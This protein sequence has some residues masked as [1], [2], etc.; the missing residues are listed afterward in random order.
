MAPVFP[1]GFVDRTEHNEVRS[2]EK[3]RVEGPWDDG[4]GDK[5]GEWRLVLCAAL[6]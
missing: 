6:W 2:R 4:A 1:G 3:V 5:E